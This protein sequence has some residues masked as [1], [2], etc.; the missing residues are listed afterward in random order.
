MNEREK[1][2]LIKEKEINIKSK[3]KN[4]LIPIPIA[5]HEID[6]ISQY[7][8]PI[9]IGL[10]Y[11]GATF[12]MNSILQCLSQT[13]DLTNYFLKDSKKRRIINNN[14]AKKN[15]N[16]LQL[17]PIY[18]KLIKK[19]WDKKGNKS[20]S[21]NEFKNTIEKMNPLFKKGQVG[22]SKDFIIYILGQ[23]H[24]ELNFYFY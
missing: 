23:I 11:N 14:L 12:F 22:D 5:P 3:D 20:F 9:L 6:P 13:S 19:L 8:K 2:I 1:R 4:I 15:K 17:S 18:L 24:K 10:N 21:P 7:I 16:S